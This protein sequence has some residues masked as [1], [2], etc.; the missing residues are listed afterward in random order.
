MKFTAKSFGIGF[1]DKHLLKAGEYY[2]RNKKKSIEVLKQKK[3]S[4]ATKETLTNKK[5]SKPFYPRKART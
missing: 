3:L 1:D 2:P 4:K 5:V